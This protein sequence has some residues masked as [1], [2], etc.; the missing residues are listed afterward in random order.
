MA[1]V[2]TPT[3][4]PRQRPPALGTRLRPGATTGIGTLPHRSVHDAAGF[5]LRKYDL[6][7]IPSLPRRSPAEGLIAQA[8]V[9]INGVT[10]GQYGSIAVD[11]AAVDPASPV[12]TDIGNDAY[13]RVAG[14][15]RCRHGAP[16]PRSGQVAVRRP[17]HPRRRPHPRRNRT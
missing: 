6:P 11:R 14:V 13:W 12:V 1:M 17:R 4:R 5:A 10:P 16:A 15:P 7:A 8:V 9:G 2:A 3:E